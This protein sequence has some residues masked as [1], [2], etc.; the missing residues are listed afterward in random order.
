MTSYV[1]RMR[2]STVILLGGAILLG[3][4]MRVSHRG[5]GLALVLLGVGLIAMGVAAAIID[6]RRTRRRR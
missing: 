2:D 4:G 3:V 1:R 6:F 5:V